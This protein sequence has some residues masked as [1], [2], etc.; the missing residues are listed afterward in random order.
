MQRCTNYQ[1]TAVN[2][3]SCKW[4]QSQGTRS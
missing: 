4:R 2:A 1:I 3:I